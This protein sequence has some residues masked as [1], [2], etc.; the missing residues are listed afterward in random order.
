MNLTHDHM[1]E[2]METPVVRSLLE[3]AAFGPTHSFSARRL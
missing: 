2:Y 1:E 3:S